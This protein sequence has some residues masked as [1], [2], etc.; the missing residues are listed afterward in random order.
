MA[1]RRYNRKRPNRNRNRRARRKVARS[2]RLIRAP[3]ICPKAVTVML[4]YRDFLNLSPGVGGIQTDNVYRINSLYDTD[5]TGGGRNQQPMGFDAWCGAAESQALYKRYT[6]QS[7][8]VKVHAQSQDSTYMCRIGVHFN[9][10]SAPIADNNYVEDKHSTIRYLT[11][12]PTADSNTDFTVYWSN[13]KTHGKTLRQINT[14]DTY[15]GQYDSSPGRISYMH[16][17]ADG[18]GTDTGN[19]RY[20]LLFEFTVRFW[21]QNDITIS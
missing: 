17:I 16:V 13:M 7:V 11:P 18:L 20:D 9:N 12:Y 3:R 2:L 21:D 5:L 6:V 1:R 10:D 4:P 14:D 8:K 15:S 19:I